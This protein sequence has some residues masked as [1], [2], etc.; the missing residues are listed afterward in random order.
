MSKSFAPGSGAAEFGRTT[1]A[2]S[3]MV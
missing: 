3:I 2:G 1:G